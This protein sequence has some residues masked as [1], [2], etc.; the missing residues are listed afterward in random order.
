[1]AVIESTLRNNLACGKDLSGELQHN[2]SFCGGMHAAADHSKYMADMPQEP[3]ELIDDL[4]RMGLYK[5]ESLSIAETLTGAELRKALFLRMVSQGDSPRQQLCNELIK[6]AGGLDQAFAAAFGHRSVEFFSDTIR[7]S[8][9]TRRDFLRKVAIGAALVT[10]ANCASQEPSETVSTP[11]AG[12]GEKTDLRVGFIP[13]TCATPIIMSEPLG[14]Y[15]KHGL[16]VKVVKMPNWA[17]VRDSAIAGEL[18]AYHMLVPMPI[19]MSLGL[20]STAFP[21]KLASIEN[22]NGQGIAVANKHKGKIKEPKDFK[23][24]K[25]GIPFP[26]S[27]HNLL[28]RYYLAA[29]GLDPNKDVDLQII[30]PPDSIAKMTAGQLDAFLMPDNFVQRA[31]Y[32]GIGFI[33]ILTKDI[34]PGHPCCAFAA[35]Q[36][37]IDSNPKSF[38]ALNKAIIDGAGYAN[39]PA[40]RQRIAQAIAPKEYLNQPVP[41]LEAVLVGKFEDGQGNTFNIPDRIKFEPYPWKSFAA[42]IATQLVRWDYLPEEKANYQEISE[43]IFLTDLARDFA[44][45]LG[46]NP[47]TEPLR[48]EKLKFDTFDPSK[49][50]E[51]VQEQIKKYGV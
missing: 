26:F 32:E 2:C 19:S 4:L 30:P 1:M 6:Q 22:N 27:N 24:L 17:A 18:D 23:G 45:E 7:N 48:V 8:Q 33:H 16:N 51:Y 14:F 47:P 13:I 15:K 29:G 36:Q 3:V 49:P 41:V 37:W 35:S 42:W 50:A 10:L 11:T 5:T 31:V 43:Q 21:I 39:N 38:Q 9:F 25:V 34:W 28:M 46:L 40:N 20:G 12:S 44:K